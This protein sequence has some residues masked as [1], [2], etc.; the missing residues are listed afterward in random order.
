[1]GHVN[2]KRKERRNNPIGREGPPRP[3]KDPLPPGPAQ[4]LVW[5]EARDGESYPGVAL[6][7]SFP[8]SEDPSILSPLGVVS[9][10]AWLESQTIDLLIWGSGS[11]LMG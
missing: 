3:V 2:K 8:P 11:L 5:T 6:P 1:M 7:P 10:P 9:G 4:P